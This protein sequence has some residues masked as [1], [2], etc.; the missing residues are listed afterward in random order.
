MSTEPTGQRNAEHP[1]GGNTPAAARIMFPEGSSPGFR[2]PRVVYAPDDAGAGGG[3]QQP[4]ADSGGQ[5]PPA[6]QQQQQQPPAQ[7]QPFTAP[8]EAGK[9]WTVGDKPWYEGIAE[10]PVKELL[11]AKNYSNPYELAMAYYNA[12]KLVNGAADAITVPGSDATPEQWDAFYTKLG[13]PE[14]PDKYEL[15]FGENVQ[16]D[17]RMV[18]FGKSLFHEMGLDPSRAQKAADKWNAFLA[19]YNGAVA[20]DWRKQNDADVDALKTRWGG[21]FDASMAAGKRTLD[22]LKGQAKAK[23]MDEAAV[24]SVIDKV[25]ANIGTAGVLELLALMGKA[26]GEGGFKGAN[27]GGDPHNPDTMSGAQAQA[28][29]NRL[30][31]DPAFYKTYTDKSD[32]QHAAAVDKMQ[33]LYARI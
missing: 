9:P 33:R 17:P 12:N 14:S 20:E 19:D 24:N 31:G 29:I 11:A 2:M 4:P 32:P 8:W 15:K 16:T 30:M 6:Q 18:E 27:G 26:S 25:E 28:E 7:Q 1:A 13:R 3:G 21:D 10:Q 23:G 5:Q 22:A